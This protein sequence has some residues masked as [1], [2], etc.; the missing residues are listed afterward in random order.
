MRVAG[1]RRGIASGGGMHTEALVALL[2]WKS[3]NWQLGCSALRAGG[4][5]H[6]DLA[7]LVRHVDGV[8]L[9]QPVLEG[10]N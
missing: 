4:T 9:D 7:F 8:V 5:T 10:S 1:A 3:V 2:W 6:H